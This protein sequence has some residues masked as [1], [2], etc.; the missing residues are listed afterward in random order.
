VVNDGDLA[1]LAAK[2]PRL[3]SDLRRGLSRKL[4]NAPA[5]RY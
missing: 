2:A 1:A 4:P 3:L 5:A